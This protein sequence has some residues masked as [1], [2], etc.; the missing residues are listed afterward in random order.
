MIKELIEE[1]DGILKN[2]LIN[3]Y[4]NNQNHIVIETI[5]KIENVNVIIKDLNKN[6]I[7]TDKKTLEPNIRYWF[8]PADKSYYLGGFIIELL[9]NDNILLYKTGFE[10]IKDKKSDYM[11][12][13]I[14]KL[15]DLYD[16][17]EEV[18]Y[19]KNIGYFDTDDDI[20]GYC[21]IHKWSRMLRIIKELGLFKKNMKFVEIGG[22][23]SPIQFI[24][25]NN[26]CQVYNFDLFFTHTWFPTI[27]KFYVNATDKFINESNKNISNINFIAGDMYETIKD[28][29]DNSIDC[30]I[31]TCSIHTFIEENEHQISKK[32]LDQITRILKPGG[33]LISVGDI[34]NPNLGNYSDLFKYPNNM[35]EILSQNENLKLIKPYDY[36]TWENELKDYNNLMVKKSVNLKDL[37]LINM[38]YDP[39]DG[40]LK[41]SFDSVYLWVATYI[42]KKQN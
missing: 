11:F 7:Y 41:G 26:G 33:Y 20:I 3:I 36:K 14:S 38:K 10:T 24:L 13:R 42:L 28:I 17:I 9:N 23:L 1:R 30:L 39:I 5:N 2:Y 21:Y 15:D 40:P 29:E 31:D 16:D 12:N 32:L 18:G 22:G 6:I 4:L 27:N 37:S 19:L 35:A 25:A 8:A 34:S